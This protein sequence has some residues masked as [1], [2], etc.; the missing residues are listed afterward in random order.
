MSVRTQPGCKVST[1]RPRPRNSLQRRGSTSST[2]PCWHD[3]TRARRRSTRRCH[4]RADEGDNAGV[5]PHRSGQRTSQPDR[6]DGVVTINDP[7]SA[8][9]AL[10]AL[11]CR[12]GDTGIDQHR[13]QCL[14]AIAAAQASSESGSFISRVSKVTR[15]GCASASARNARASSG[16]RAVATTDQPSANSRSTTRG[17]CP[18]W[19]P[20]PK[21]KNRHERNSRVWKRVYFWGSTTTV[22]VL[23][24]CSTDK[25]AAAVSYKGNVPST[26][27]IRP[28]VATNREISVCARLRSAC[29]WSAARAAQGQVPRHE[30][31]QRDRRLQRAVGGVIRDRAVLRHRGQGR[32]QVARQIDIDDMVG[33]SP[34]VRSRTRAA[35]SPSYN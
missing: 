18:D 12:A 30:R 14:P 24:P 28:G 15:S 29:G 34:P 21:P 25:C 2:P 31:A 4:R 10:L 1:V 20:P 32:G 26:D 17:R 3:T 5:L 22:P 7:I 13:V 16:R 33:H 23:P 9:V 11:R 19:R 35:T 27:R 6:R 8:S